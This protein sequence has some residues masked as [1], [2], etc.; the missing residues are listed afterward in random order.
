MAGTWE[1]IV[2][3]GK[4]GK[5]DEGGAGAAR[6]DGEGRSLEVDEKLIVAGREAMEMYFDKKYPESFEEYP[7]LKHFFENFGCYVAQYT[8]KGSATSGSGRVTLNVGI[9]TL[10]NID[11]KFLEKVFSTVAGGYSLETD[12]LSDLTSAEFPHIFPQYAALCERAGKLSIPINSPFDPILIIKPEHRPI[13]AVAAKEYC[14]RAGVPYVDE[15]N[16]KFTPYLPDLE[17]VLTAAKDYEVKEIKQAV[18]AYSR[19]A[20]SL[21]K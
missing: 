21:I 14:E 20:L 13:M 9:V 2:S 12:L 7:T 17:A 18:V 1:D 19:A 10:E 8:K 15:D 5:K 16:S 3:E 4:K 6:G 11:K